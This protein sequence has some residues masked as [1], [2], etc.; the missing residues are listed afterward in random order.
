MLYEE[1]FHL[2]YRSNYLNQ[3]FNNTVGYGT[4]YST[5][6]S[7]HPIFICHQTYHPAALDT[8]KDSFADIHVFRCGE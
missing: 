8:D 2:A 7:Y 3:L 1:N 5:D 4:S 6:Y